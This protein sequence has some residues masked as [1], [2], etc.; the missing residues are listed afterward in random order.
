MRSADDLVG[1]A[2]PLPALRARSA[3]SGLTV[4]H[5]LLDRMGGG[6]VVVP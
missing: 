4:S 6:A 3:A 1:E 5:R 2:E